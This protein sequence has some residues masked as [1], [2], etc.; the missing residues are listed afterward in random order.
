MKVDKCLE[1]KLLS[2]GHWWLMPIILAN[3]EEEIGGS[4]F[5]ASLD[6]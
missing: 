4:W 3:Q 1:K 5:E 2:A 6:K